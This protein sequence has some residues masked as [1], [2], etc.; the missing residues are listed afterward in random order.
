MHIIYTLTYTG[1]STVG[2]PDPLD[3]TL[4]ATQGFAS[5]ARHHLHLVLLSP[6]EA[7]G[8]LGCRTPGPKWRR[9][10][11]YKW[12]VI[13]ERRKVG[14]GSL[15]NRFSCKGRVKNWSFLVNIQV[16]EVHCSARKPLRKPSFG[17]TNPGI[18]VKSC[19]FNGKIMQNVAFF[20][21]CLLP[22]WWSQREVHL[23]QFPGWPLPS[24]QSPPLSLSDLRYQ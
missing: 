9:F 6:A 17:G 24:I 20:G 10:M 19:I 5:P 14:T 8:M 15:W 11:A 23:H 13:L 22:V 7:M 4:I 21:G 3:S 12:G 1:I 18:V 16:N 2:L